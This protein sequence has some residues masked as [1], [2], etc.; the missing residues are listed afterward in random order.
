MEAPAGAME[1][2]R[3]TMGVGTVSIAP[4]GAMRGTIRLS[5]GSVAAAPSDVRLSSIEPPARASLTYQVTFDALLDK[6]P[7]FAGDLDV[8]LRPAANRVLLI[9]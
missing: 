6:L 8:F 9:L 3:R 7:M 1:F 2:A 4:S 5:G